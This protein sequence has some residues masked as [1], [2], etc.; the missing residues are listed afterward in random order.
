M[1]NFAHRGTS[2]RFEFGYLTT[3]GE[4]NQWITRDRES[5]QSYRVN[6]NNMSAAFKQ[7]YRQDYEIK[8]R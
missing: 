4:R 1:D 5:G 6:D 8:N 2:G 3:P 7:A